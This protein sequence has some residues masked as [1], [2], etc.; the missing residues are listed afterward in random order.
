MNGK[1][2]NELLPNEVHDRMK[3][4]ENV[5]IIDVRE[6]DEWESG[7]IPGAKHIPLGQITGALNEIN[8]KEETIVVCRSGNRSGK[9]CEYLSSLGFKV[10][11]MSG[12]MSAWSGDIEIG[13]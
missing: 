12:G 2:Y 8:P 4:K 1:A 11:N 5:A 9:A 10:L 13:K 7:H 3:S 6:P